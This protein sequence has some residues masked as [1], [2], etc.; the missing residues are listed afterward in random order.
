LETTPT[1]ARKIINLINIAEKTIEKHPYL[2]MFFRVFEAMIANLIKNK[3][4]KD[5]T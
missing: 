5:S 2:P 1:R 4:K 3:S